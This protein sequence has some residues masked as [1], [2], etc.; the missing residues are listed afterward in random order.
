[1]SQVDAGPSMPGPEDWKELRRRWGW[2]LL[3]GVVLVILGLIAIGHVLTAAVISVF[4]Y[5]CLLAI[6]GGVETLYAVWARHWSGF[7]LLLLDGMLS[8]L[9]GILL[10]R[11]P[12]ASIAIL[13]FVLAIFFIFGGSMRLVAALV[14]A[15]PH[16]IWQFLSGLVGIALGVLV[17]LQWPEDSWWFFGLFVG[18]ELVFNGWSLIMLS[19]LARRFLST[20]A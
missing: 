19:L 8:L 15:F 7:F 6:S 10:L 5:G 20:P 13:T 17:L 11:F 18:I 1:M 16:R 2:I 3:V 12:I 14:W 9:V 4:V